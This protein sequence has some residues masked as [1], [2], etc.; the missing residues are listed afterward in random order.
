MTKIL[1]APSVI[2]KLILG[3]V[4]ISRSTVDFFLYKA[5]DRII[6]FDV[7]ETKLTMLIETIEENLFGPG[8]ST[9]GPTDLLERQ[10]L[11]RTRLEKVSKN[12]GNLADTIQSPALNKHLMYCLF[13]IIVAEMYPELESTIS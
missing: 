1:Q 11:A 5:I 9:P 4:H 12:L 7:H 3:L 2:V 13:D 6:R 10:R 8:Q